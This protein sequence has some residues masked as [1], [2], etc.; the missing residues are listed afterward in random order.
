MCSLHSLVL[1]GDEL[2]ANLFMKGL[3]R[4][5]TL[6][7][8]DLEGNM[9]RLGRLCAS[10]LEH[11]HQLLMPGALPTLLGQIHATDQS[12][13]MAMYARPR[14]EDGARTVLIAQ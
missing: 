7:E 6:T 3:R 14:D 1:V 4:R 12:R 9:D 13:E 2:V 11:G 5:H 10:P 8:D